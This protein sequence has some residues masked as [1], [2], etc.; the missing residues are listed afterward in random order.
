MENKRKNNCVDFGFWRFLTFAKKKVLLVPHIVTKFMCIGCYF[1]NQQRELT[2]RHARETEKEM[3]K[4]LD[5]QKVLSPR[6]NTRMMYCHH[7]SGFPDYL[8]VP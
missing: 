5:M 3:K 1:Q 2:V 7:C 4:R 8:F 6:P